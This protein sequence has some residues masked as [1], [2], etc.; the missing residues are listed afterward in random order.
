MWVGRGAAKWPRSE[1]L[2]A[3]CMVSNLSASSDGTSSVQGPGLALLCLGEPSGEPLWQARQP[4]THVGANA[5]PGIDVDT[6]THVRVGVRGSYTCACSE[7][8]WFCFRGELML[9]TGE[10]LWQARQQCIYVGAYVRVGMR[11]HVRTCARQ[12]TESCAY[13]LAPIV[14]VA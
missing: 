7:S 14:D 1:H 8:E 5:C 4:S 9:H 6:H 13:I 3:I 11:K 10:P 12:R 2:S